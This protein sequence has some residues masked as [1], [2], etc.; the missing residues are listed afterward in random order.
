[1]GGRGGGGDGYDGDGW[2]DYV[3]VVIVKQLRTAVTRMCH[4]LKSR[5]GVTV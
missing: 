2:S 5:G 3:A 1:M 4:T